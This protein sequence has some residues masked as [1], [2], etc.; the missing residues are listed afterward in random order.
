M[1]VSRSFL[2]GFRGKQAL[3][4]DGRAGL[5]L[6]ALG[7]FPKGVNLVMGH[8][9]GEVGLSFLGPPCL[10]LDPEGCRQQKRTPIG[11]GEGWACGDTE[12]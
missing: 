5:P 2:G 12:M 1:T 10:G 7:P 11:G 3:G 4:V 8:G 9:D 6:C